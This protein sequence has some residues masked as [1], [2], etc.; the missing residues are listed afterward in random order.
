[1]TKLGDAVLKNQAW[2]LSAAA[3]FGILI[4]DSAA[5]AVTTPSYLCKFS[6]PNSAIY[7]S[8]GKI[9]KDSS[10]ELDDLD[11]SATE[12]KDGNIIFHSTAPD[13]KALMVEIS[14]GEGSDGASAYDW[15]YLGAINSESSRYSMVGGC[16]KFPDGAT[17]RQVMGLAKNDRLKLRAKRNSKSAILAVAKLATFVWVYPDQRTKGWTHVAT[18]VYPKD[19]NGMIKVVDGW[20]NAKFIGR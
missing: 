18:A 4:F 16:L 17:P 12:Q 13:G 9:K 14:K 11:I 1:M 15:P 7:I 19:D 2:M 20:V 3:L 5:L 6:E 8:E 10:R